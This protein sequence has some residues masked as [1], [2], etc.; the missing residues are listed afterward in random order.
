MSDKPWH[1][2]VAEPY[3][4]AAIE[5]LATVGRVTALSSCDESSLMAAVPDADA[6]VVRT[7][8]RVTRQVIERA[9]RLKV[10]GRGGTGLESIDLEA[11]TERGIKIV[12]TPQ[13]ST[14][15][16]ADLTLGMILAL[17]RNFR[18]CDGAVRTGKFKA[19][20]EAQSAPELHEL[21]I[22]IIGLGRIGRA[23]ARRCRVGFGA[24]VLYSD[25]VAPGLLDFVAEPRD[26]I[27]LYREAD[28]VSLHVPLTEQTRNLI[29]AEALNRF[30]RGAYLVN[31]SRGAAVDLAATAEALRTG[32][33]A[34]VAL[35]VFDTEPLPP[36]HPLL[37]APNT[38]LTP[39]I[40][41]RTSASL[42][43]MSA[44]VE[45]VI[46]VLEGRQ[47]EFGL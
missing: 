12:Y 18:T 26:K 16:V 31:T 39:H 13:A 47:P 44:V 36:D 8:S 41:A 7:G 29:N 46:R 9:G 22:G 2:V 42:S 45:D 4:P 28:V 23:V 25:I 14:D 17:I 15:A 33:L 10:I 30:K 21:T 34:G 5:R 20:R 35:D 1:I 32:R 24:R 40:G 27:D 3:G 6:L 38:F 43:R 19:V 37:R 11:A